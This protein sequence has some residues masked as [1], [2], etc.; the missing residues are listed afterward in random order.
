MVKTKARRAVKVA[1]V[2]SVP[3]LLR[4]HHAVAAD[5]VVDL[6]IISFSHETKNSDP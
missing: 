3:C 2:P 1:I 4:A 5:L 6:P